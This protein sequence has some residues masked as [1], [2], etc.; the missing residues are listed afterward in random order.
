MRVKPIP[1]AR[2]AGPFR[3][4]ERPIRPSDMKT[5]KTKEKKDLRKLG[6][7]AKQTAA[8]AALAVSLFFGGLFSSPADVVKPG[9][10]VPSQGIVISAQLPDQ[11][12]PAVPALGSSDEKRGFRD[13]ARAW[14][15]SLP[16]AVR[17]LFVLPFWAVGFG[18]IWAVSA[19]A[20]LIN[21]PI[22]GT[23]IKILL[24]ALVVFG[25]VIGAE[26]L[27]FPNVPL[28][29]LLSKRNVT[30]LGICS[31]VIASAGALGGLFWRDKPYITAAI[32][33]GAAALYA[34]FLLVF[35]RKPKPKEAV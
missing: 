9:S 31:V 7:K 26:K 10:D 28:K 6:K 24:G 35:V 3:K 27:L 25:L 14:I 19:L 17:I 20:G 1:A 33:V 34:V 21:V 16:L 2:G 23:V 30:A 15:K 5:E 18:I 11:P 4:K 12:D 22:I 8:G 29:K 32:D 13:R